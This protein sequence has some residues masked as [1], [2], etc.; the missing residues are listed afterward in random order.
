MTVLEWFSLRKECVYVWT[1]FGELDYLFCV[2]L[3]SGIFVNYFKMSQDEYISIQ[4]IMDLRS[5]RSKAK[6][7]L[8]KT[9]KELYNLIEQKNIPDLKDVSTLQV[10]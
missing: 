8:L 1:I 6:R 4:D 7:Q 9:V 10:M 3:S 5:S 2:W